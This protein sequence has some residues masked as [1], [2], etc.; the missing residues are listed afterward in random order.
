MQCR[1]PYT[2]QTMISVRLNN[3]SLKYV[4]FTPLGG[5]YLGIRKVDFVA[6]TQFFITRLLPFFSTFF[7]YFFQ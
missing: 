3:Q 1:R 2:F 4:W 6:K 7:I 5:K